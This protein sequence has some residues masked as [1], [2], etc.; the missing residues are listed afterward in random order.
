MNYRIAICDDNKKDI[1]NL[2]ALLEELQMKIAIDDEISI[3]ISNFNS[4]KMLLDAC[5]HGTTFDLLLLDIEMPEVSGMDIAK[6]LR[7]H[8]D[9][10]TQIAFISS[11][12]EYM[13]DSFDVEAFSFLIKPITYEQLESLW[14]RLMQ[15]NLREK[16]IKIIV[17]DSNGYE[18][19]NTKDILY[20]I[21]SSE[22]RSYV[23]IHL[24][25]DKTESLCI[26]QGTIN[27]FQ[28]SLSRFNFVQCYKSILVNLEHIQFINGYEITLINKKIIPLSRKYKPN[29]QKLYAENSLISFKQR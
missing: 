3:N 10:D 22:F 7:L 28:E 11:Y 27:S 15:K 9:F 25:K 23:E 18:F 16:M 13:K 21:T 26:A 20:I 5:R 8:D 1:E 6:H 12:P 4:S 17:K 2:N 19:I 24:Y 14:N 29:L